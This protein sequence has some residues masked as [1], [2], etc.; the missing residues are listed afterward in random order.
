MICWFTQ[1][2]TRL[3]YKYQDGLHGPESRS[4]LESLETKM[5]KIS[6]RLRIIRLTFGWTQ[7]NRSSERLKRNTQDEFEFDIAPLISGQPHPELQ[8][9]IERLDSHL[10]FLQGTGTGTSVNWPE[11][12][13]ARVRRVA[14]ETMDFFGVELPRGDD[15][16]PFFAHPASFPETWSWGIAFCLA[17][18]RLSRMR[19]A[20][21][22]HWPT[23]DTTETILLECIF[24]ACVTKCI[25]RRSDDHYE[26]KMLL[27]EKYKPILGLPIA[28]AYHDG[29]AF[30]V[31]H[32]EH[33]KGMFSGW[34]TKPASI[35]DRLTGD[36]ENNML[37]EPRTENYLKSDYD[38]SVYPK[39]KEIIMDIDLPKEVYDKTHKPKDVPEQSLE[40]L[41]WNGEEVG[42]EL[43]QDAT[44]IFQ[45]GLSWPEDEDAEL[46]D[47]E[48]PADA[49]RPESEATS[50]SS[51]VMGHSRL[52]YRKITNES[53]ALGKI[54][55]R[56]RSIESQAEPE[57]EL[58]SEMQSKYAEVTKRI[59]EQGLDPSA[60]LGLTDLLKNL[61]EAKD[62]ED[63]ESFMAILAVLCAELN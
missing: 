52:Y 36:H 46:E 14:E 25:L 28:L 49:A 1:E 57:S 17:Y 29:L 26:Q 63:E 61:R 24:Q 37:I 18:E 5:I 48:E 41:A 42:D 44:E 3:E 27:K 55:V 35:R 2:R 39:L 56:S 50:L 12:D 51:K 8:R 15:G 40:D 33:G 47:Y 7:H 60:D 23:Y 20:C 19:R 11:A 6:K 32:R 16:C 9:S 22:R 58:Q 21:N 4:E 31:G 53:Q 59:Q 34:P 43:L 54:P 62:R 45:T 10:N 38:S 30:A 13:L